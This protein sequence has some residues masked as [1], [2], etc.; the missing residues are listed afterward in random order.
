MDRETT[1]TS[2]RGFAA[3]L[4]GLVAG[5][6]AMVPTPASASRGWCR[7]DPLIRID[8][9]L[10]DILA[11]A[12]PE[13][14]LANNGPVEF[15]ITVPNGVDTRLIVKTVGFGRGEKVSFATSRR[16]NQTRA[17]MQVKIA[18]RVPARMELPVRVEFAP[19]IVG[20][21]KPESVEGTT[22]RW[23]TLKTTL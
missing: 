19:R 10:A 6:A 5:V 4:F 11:A 18:M 7:M 13:I 15:V 20:L 1:M 14:L 8:D 22:N 17:G 9:D 3:A 2:R 12:P 16:L 23:V 21:L